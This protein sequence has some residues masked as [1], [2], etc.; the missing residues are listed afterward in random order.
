MDSD[1]MSASMPS[2]GDFNLRITTSTLTVS[3]FRI[4]LF[5]SK[6]DAACEYEN[7]LST[8]RSLVCRTHVCDRC[9]RK[10]YDLSSKIRKDFPLE[11]G[12]HNVKS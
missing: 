1:T 12:T 10:G 5:Y 2:F 7:I 3:S 4:L 6:R 11:Q 8:G 9:K